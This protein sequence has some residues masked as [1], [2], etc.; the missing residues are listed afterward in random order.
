MNNRYNSVEEIVY[1][2][3]GERIRK[4]RK[5]NGLTQSQIGSNNLT[6]ISKDVISAIENGKLFKTRKTFITDSEFVILCEVFNI[7][8][9]GRIIFGQSEEEVI[10]LIYKIY[11]YVAYHLEN[12]PDHL[13][14]NEYCNADSNIALS[15]QEL[16]YTFRFSAL[17]TYYKMY[18]NHTLETKRFDQSFSDSDIK[19]LQEQYDKLINFFWNDNKDKIIDSFYNLFNNLD[20]ISMKNFKSLLSGEWVNICFKST[21]VDIKKHYESIG[22]YKLGYV[23]SDEIMDNIREEIHHYKFEVDYN[24]NLLHMVRAGWR[25]KENISRH[26][27]RI[28]E[29]TIALYED[30]MAQEMNLGIYS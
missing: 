17:Y 27:K 30:A 22:F 12:I 1:R 18:L 11:R 2:T 10:D 26:R 13:Y 3:I 4:I 23:I 25:G 8:E 21:L 28:D 6:F 5:E 7:R 29:N 15:A 24:K 16:Q 19:K 9:K 20:Y 14:W